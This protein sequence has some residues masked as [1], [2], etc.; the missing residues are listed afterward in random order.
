MTGNETIQLRN[1][2]HIRINREK[3]KPSDDRQYLLR[4][5]IVN[6][7]RNTLNKASAVNADATSR[8]CPDQIYAAKVAKATAIG[9]NAYSIP[10]SDEMT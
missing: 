4:G 3:C 5:N 1:E 9:V 8:L 7:K 6:G 10:A 2:V